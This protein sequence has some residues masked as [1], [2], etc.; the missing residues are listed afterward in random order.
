MCSDEKTVKFWNSVCLYRRHARFF[1]IMYSHASSLSIFCTIHDISRFWG[2]KRSWIIF[3]Q[4][5]CT[6]VYDLCTVVHK[7]KL[8]IW[9]LSLSNWIKHNLHNSYHIQTPWYY[10]ILVFE[11]N[12]LHFKLKDLL[13][14]K[15]LY[16]NSWSNFSRIIL[17]L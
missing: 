3:I 6:L 15:I 12:K 17:C 7:P 13:R 14:V 4:G 8:S 9:V 2:K 11:C 5:S 10:Y 16:L 1:M